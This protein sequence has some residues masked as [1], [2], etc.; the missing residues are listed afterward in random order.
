MKNNLPPSEPPGTIFENTDTAAVIF[1][2][3]NTILLANEEFEKLA[4]YTTR[5]RLL[6]PHEI[7]SL[8]D[9]TDPDNKLY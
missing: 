4:G 9:K 6:H 5:N 2:E 1:E 3:N 8:V 7:R